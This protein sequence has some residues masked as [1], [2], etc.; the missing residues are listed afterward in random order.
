[1]RQVPVAT[2]REVVRQVPVPQVQ[3]VEEVVE[4][5]QAQTVR[6]VMPVPRVIPQEIVPTIVK[7]LRGMLP[8][9]NPDCREGC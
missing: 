1:M 8:C 4:A 7:A 3:T 6:K 2:S 9:P 5:S